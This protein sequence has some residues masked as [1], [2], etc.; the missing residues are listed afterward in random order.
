MRTVGQIMKKRTI[1]KIKIYKAMMK[2][3]LMLQ[4]QMKKIMKNLDSD[5]SMRENEN[6]SQEGS[7]EQSEEDTH[8]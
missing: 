3:P 7:Q 2:T 1:M 8:T 4:I 5:T 6:S